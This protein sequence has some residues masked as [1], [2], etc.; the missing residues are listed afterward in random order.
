MTIVTAC[1][2]ALYGAIAI[3]GGA[4]GIGKPRSAKF[5]RSVSGLLAWAAICAWHVVHMR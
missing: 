5:G 3:W 4:I 1:L 2:C